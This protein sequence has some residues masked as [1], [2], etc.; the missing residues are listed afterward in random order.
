M[1]NFGDK[2]NKSLLSNRDLL[3]LQGEMAQL[4]YQAFNAFIDVIN[5]EK[6]DKIP[7][8][9]PVGFNADNTPINSTHD[10]TK[11]ELIARYKYLALDKLPLDGIYQLVTLMETQFG[12]IIRMTFSAIQSLEQ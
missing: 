7:T 6:S 5:K 8:T 9:Y 1:K 10:Y 4:S 11:E 3:F 2:L 12:D